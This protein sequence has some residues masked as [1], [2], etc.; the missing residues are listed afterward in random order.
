MFASRCIRSVL[1]RRLRQPPPP[2]A[3]LLLLSRGAC[4]PAAPARRA[5][6]VGAATRVGSGAGAG[7]EEEEE[8]EEARIA[9]NGTAFPLD[10][11]YGIPVLGVRERWP[12]VVD[13][14]LHQMRTN[15]GYFVLPDFLGDGGKVATALREDAVAL[16]GNG[17]F[18]ASRSVG[19][20]GVAY[21]KY[22]VESCELD[23]RPPAQPARPPGPVAFG[24]VR[25]CSASARVHMRRRAH[26]ARM[27]ARV[28]ATSLVRTK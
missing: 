24:R 26:T 20:D 27:P 13:D 2:P 7:K 18:V 14:C 3:L 5:L 23:G 25:R 19:T 6:H 11:D 9:V 4:A 12:E 1:A 28:R 10:P 21:D 15:G 17:R 22:N 8:E 16:R